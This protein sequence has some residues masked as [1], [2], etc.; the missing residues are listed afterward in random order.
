MST[1][2]EVHVAKRIILCYIILRFIIFRTV[3]KAL[4]RKRDVGVVLGFIKSCNKM[5]LDY[6]K[7]IES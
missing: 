6:V 3:E 4:P 2:R 5:L 7:S 1:G